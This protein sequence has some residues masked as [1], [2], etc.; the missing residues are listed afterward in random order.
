[1]STRAIERAQA[2]ARQ[3]SHDQ[4]RTEHLVLGLL[5]EP[6]GIAARA[7]EALGAPAEQVRA[8]VVAAF[9]PAAESV[10]AYVPFGPHAKKVLELTLREAFRLGHDYV[11]TEHILLGLLSD[12]DFGGAKVLVERGVTKDRVETWVVAVLAALTEPQ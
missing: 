4:V 3:A 8:A 1:M 9:G 12:E 6:D 11:G 10:P 2:E 5:A 7:I